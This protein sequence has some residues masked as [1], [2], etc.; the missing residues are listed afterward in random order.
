M[1]REK[2]LN[3][4]LLIGLSILIT[5][6]FAQVRSLITD[7]IYNHDENFA[8]YGQSKII[9]SDGVFVYGSKDEYYDNIF[10]Q[11]THTYHCLIN[12]SNHFWDAYQADTILT[13]EE[14]FAATGYLEFADKAKGHQ[15]RMQFMK[16]SSPFLIIGGLLMA[17]ISSDWGRESGTSATTVAGLGISL[18]GL[19][20][21][22]EAISK[23]NSKKFEILEAIRVVDAYNKLLR[24]ELGL[25][26]SIEVKED[27]IETA[28]QTLEIEV[29]P[30]NMLDEKA[31]Q[32]N[33]PQMPFPGLHS[34]PVELVVQALIDTNGTVVVC[35]MLKTSGIK[36]FDAVVLNAFQK[37]KFT[38]P[39][40][41]GQKVYTIIARPL[42]FNVR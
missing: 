23:S 6:S 14:F 22:A 9:I 12:K 11:S 31:K 10:K 39:K 8:I 28:V 21:G 13:E 27:L 29:V 2:M 37:T 26:D 34:H 19:T 41:H 1:N 30:Y 5:V 3:R 36:A 20:F 42:K 38:P 4:I 16:W 15:Q 25:K 40:Q 24:D 33:N 17:G 35:Q 32:L 7:S 18:T